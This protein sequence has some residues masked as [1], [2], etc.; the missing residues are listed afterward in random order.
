MLKLR[1]GLGVTILNLAASQLCQITRILSFAAVQLCPMPSV[2]PWVERP[3]VAQ[4]QWLISIRV[5]HRNK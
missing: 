3:V 1:S 2:D 5:G 4:H